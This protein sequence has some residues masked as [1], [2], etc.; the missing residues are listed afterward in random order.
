MVHFGISR[1]R[2]TAVT[3]AQGWSYPEAM[4]TEPRSF[5][6]SD[7]F[8]ESLNFWF[9]LRRTEGIDDATL[10]ER[11]NEWADQGSFSAQRQQ[12]A[13]FERHV[14]V[15]DHERWREYLRIWQPWKRLQVERQIEEIHAQKPD[16]A[17][18]HYKAMAALGVRLRVQWVMAPF[19]ERR[20]VPP[21]LAVMGVEG[22]TSDSRTQAVLE[23]ARALA[24]SSSAC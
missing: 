4:Q 1:R 5:S 2:Q 6:W 3:R 8:D 12:E 13:L 9:W 24:G 20:L 21:D 7:D 18:A 11:L 15:R 17:R 14:Q 19:G 10:L 22:A 23:A 16:Y